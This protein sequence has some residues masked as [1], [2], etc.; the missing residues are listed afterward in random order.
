MTPMARWMIKAAVQNG[1]SLLP[2][3]ASWN[4]VF[5]KYVTKSI[6]LD[7]DRLRIKL[8]FYA[9]RHITSCFT[10]CGRKSP[11][12]LELGTGWY[13]VIP[14]AFY[15]CGASTIWTIDNRLL[16]ENAAIHNTLRLF[17]R[18]WR[19]GEL[20]T[21][22]PHLDENRA[23]QLNE[24]V[25]T[26]E[27]AR[28]VLDA[29]NIDTL[30][31]DARCT[32]LEDASVDFIFSN[33]VLQEIPPAVLHGLFHEFRRVLSAEGCMSHYVNMVEPYA[34]SDPSL[35]PF[36]FLQYSD[37][38][39]RI[40]DNSVHSHNRL[41]IREYRALHGGAGFDI[42]E[43][44]NERGERIELERVRLAKRFQAYSTDDLL[45]VNTWLVS[46]PQ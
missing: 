38:S 40:L 39:W 24:L 2:A 19:A 36:H 9:A 20:A 29:L 11:V 42:V 5:Q 27:A 6:G 21:L 7:E 10:Y 8:R 44:D 25:N 22:L 33:S 35:T 16:L 26:G 45:V 43:E 28:H 12:V 30:V 46:R 17:A 31:Q 14:I 32:A 3:S 13:P 34:T 23:R 41:R 18:L 37:R 1:I 15:L 4:Y